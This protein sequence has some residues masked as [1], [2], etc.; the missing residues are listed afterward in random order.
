MIILSSKASW[1]ESPFRSPESYEFY[2][3]NDTFAIV[4]TATYVRPCQGKTRKSNHVHLIYLGEAYLATPP[5]SNLKDRD[6][7]S[8]EAIYKSSAH[9]LRAS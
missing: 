7:Y 4:E 5:D 8:P 6:H 3:S 1:K 2:E 9:L